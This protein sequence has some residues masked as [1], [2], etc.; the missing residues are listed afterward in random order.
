MRVFDNYA[1]FY[2]LLYRDKDYAGEAHFVHQLLKPYAD[3]NYQVFIKDKS[4][5]AVEELQETHRM[6]YLFPPQVNL[7]VA[8][9][10]LQ[11]I[12]YKEWITNREPGWDTWSV[13]CLGQ[14]Q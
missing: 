5:A 10:G 14:S 8:N 13:Y 9:S 4:S 12:T 6:R 1:R 7:L 3:V 11:S 2:D